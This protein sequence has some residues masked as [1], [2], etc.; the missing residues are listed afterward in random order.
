MGCDGIFDIYSTKKLVNKIWDYHAHYYPL[1]E[2]NPQV[3]Y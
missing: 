3:F 2:R 1:K